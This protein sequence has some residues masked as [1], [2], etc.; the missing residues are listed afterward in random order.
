MMHNRP[1]WWWIALACTTVLLVTI[2]VSFGWVMGWT[3]GGNR[4]YLY[5]EHGVLHGDNAQPPGATPSARPWYGSFEFTSSLIYD[6]WVPFPSLS[7]A[8]WGNWYFALPLHFPLLALFIVVIVPILPPVVKRRRRRR[9][10]CVNCKYD[11]TANESGK[12][13]ECGLALHGMTRSTT[14]CAKDACEG[15]P[16]E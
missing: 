3:D 5:I 12:C 11:L 1:L 8:P 14:P 2:F 4:W 13:P 7:H 9:G 6:P 10:Q 16:S 15:K